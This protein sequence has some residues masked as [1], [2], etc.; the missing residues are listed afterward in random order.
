MF[1]LAVL[2]LC[3]SQFRPVSPLWGSGLGG[4]RDLLQSSA[5][6]ESGWALRVLLSD[7]NLG[8]KMKVQTQNTDPSMQLLSQ[9][10]IISFWD[11]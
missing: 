2:I 9:F 5:R 3:T 11:Y 1:F 8:L 7:A 6:Q 10:G 4:R